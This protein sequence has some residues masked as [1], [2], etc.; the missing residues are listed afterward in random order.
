MEGEQTLEFGDIIYIIG[1][2][3]V[4]LGNS[5]AVNN[6]KNN[7]TIKNLKE[8]IINT[9][10]DGEASSDDIEEE[11]YF[12][13]T[14][15]KIEVIDN[16]SFSLEKCPPKQKQEKQPLLLTIGPSFTM[17]IPMA[18]G[19]ALS[20]GSGFGAGGIAMSVGAAGIGAVW[21]VIN[22]KH[23]D[24]MFAEA[25][26]N[27]VSSYEAYAVKMTGQIREKMEYNIGV[28]ERKYPSADEAAEI[29]MQDEIVGAFGERNGIVNEARDAGK[30]ISEAMKDQQ[31]IVILI[32]DYSSF[33][34]TIYSEDYGMDG[35]FETAFDKG[36]YH[37]INFIAAMTT[38]DVD[39][40][41]RYMAS[42]QFTSM[43][44]GVNMGGMFDQQNVLH[45]EMSAADSVR[46]LN[47]GFG[48][49]L[50]DNGAPAK[51]LTPLV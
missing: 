37:K 18:L 47:A 4:Y 20:L 33:I 29:G 13:R 15:R 9:S 1:L 43:E 50:D 8:I 44:S 30:S 49:A 7:V 22:S 36:R 41:A 39:D 31:R 46:Q 23:Q 10:G 17:I 2:K 12:L 21:A 32:N 27:R 11:K 19:A 40:C 48:Y 26:N 16:E 14:P 24:K 34:E 42:R 45:W 25:E 5:L 38:D 3:I 28:L 35:F 6:P 51:M